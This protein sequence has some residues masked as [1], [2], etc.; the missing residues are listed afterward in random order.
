MPEIPIVLKY[1]ERSFRVGDRVKCFVWRMEDP[2]LKKWVSGT[3]EEFFPTRITWIG[4]MRVMIKKQ[5]EM[6]KEMFPGQE[7]KCVV[8]LDDEEQ[9]SIIYDDFYHIRMGIRTDER[10]SNNPDDLYEGFGWN[11]SGQHVIFEH[12]AEYD[13]MPKEGNQP[14]KLPF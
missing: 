10:V 11:T 3:V 9:D 8:V 13:P 2:A 5:W 12:E 14:H 4:P 7:L 6:M 1:F